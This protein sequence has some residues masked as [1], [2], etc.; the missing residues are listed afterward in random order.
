M[1]SLKELACPQEFNL[2]EGLNDLDAHH[3]VLWS[4]TFRPDSSGNQSLSPAVS[5]DFKMKLGISM[6]LAHHEA[7]SVTGD[8]DDLGLLA[9][10]SEFEVTMA[11]GHTGGAASFVHSEKLFNNTH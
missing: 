7:D 10:H 8:V 3:L 9:V 5:G 2:L 1:F 11:V 4:H 6:L